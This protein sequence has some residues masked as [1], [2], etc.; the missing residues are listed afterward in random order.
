M[1]T[2]SRLV[3]S[4]PMEQ[5]HN[6]IELISSL[7]KDPG[8]YHRLLGCLLYLT[9]T[10]PK[11][12]YLVHMMVQFMQE[13]RE[14]HWNATIRIM[15]YLK[16]SPRQGI[17]LTTP[18]SLWLVAL[19][20]SD[21]SSCPVTR[22]STTDYFVSLGGCPISYR[23]KKQMIVSH[24]SAEAKYRSMA[25]TTSELIWLR[26]LLSSLRVSHDGPM[27]IHCDN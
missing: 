6:L 25:I 3:S 4:I 26:N 16:H 10:R 5:R 18:S 15:R 24:S 14:H 1:W 21:W 27:M 20:D 17:L 12:C 19:S 8:R 11:L 13:P 2:I 22:Q 9:I 7:L 23:T